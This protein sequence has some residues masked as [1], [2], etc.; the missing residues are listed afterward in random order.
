MDRLCQVH[1]AGAAGPVAKHRGRSE[2]GG[3]E[4]RDR[5]VRAAAVRDAGREDP[6][7]RAGRRRSTA[8]PRSSRV[9]VGSASPRWS[10]W[11]TATASSASATA[12][13]RRC[14]R[15]SP[16][17]SRRPRSTSSR[18][19]GS[20]A[21]I[22]HPVLGEAAAGVVLLKPATAGTGVIAGGP[23]R[24]VLEC[25]GIHDV[26]SQEPRLVESDQHR[27]RHRGRAA[28]AGVAGGGRGPPWPAGRGRGAGGDAGGARRVG[29]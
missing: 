4:G 24:A 21:S 23:V 12:R 7:P 17:V 3:R 8:S 1:S 11:A 14:P 20:V 18:C 2:G 6:A 29:A 22:P 5:G 13:P 27:A 19:R 9:V 15:R 10:S 28:R 26:L 25:A 16:R